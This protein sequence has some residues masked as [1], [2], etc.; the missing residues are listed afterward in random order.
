MLQ[1]LVWNSWRR[2][3]T[4]LRWA[5]TSLHP[6]E[7]ICITESTWA[8]A[9]SCTTR[10]SQVACIGGRLKRCLYGSIH[11]RPTCVGQISCALEFRAGEVIRRA[12]SRVGEDCYRLLTNN[13][14]HFCEWCLRGE[15]RSY[16]VEAL[17]ARLRVLYPKSVSSRSRPP[18]SDESACARCGLP[19]MR[20]RHRSGPRQSR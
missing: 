11:P 3:V 12:R 5:H 8:M 10:D 14:E 19:Q 9:G 2:K 4:S 6:A 7:A 16:Q 13:C 17:L 20:E 1:W 18:C 15:H